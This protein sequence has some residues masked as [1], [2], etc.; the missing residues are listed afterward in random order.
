M[1]TLEKRLKGEWYLPEAS[2]RHGDRRCDCG[3]KCKTYEQMMRWG[4]AQVGKVDPYTEP[5]QG[6]SLCG[7]CNKERIRQGKTAREFVG[8]PRVKSKPAGR[9]YGGK[10]TPVPRLKAM[11]LEQGLT[12]EE[13]AAAAGVYESTVMRIEEREKTSGQTAKK[14]ANVLGVR[15]KELRESA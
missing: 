10:A 6:V 8:L 9:Y 13:L 2:T 12:L 4:D 14:L 1:S 15:V 5:N 7:L 3:V 11:R